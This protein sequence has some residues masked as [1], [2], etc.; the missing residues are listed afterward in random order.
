MTLQKPESFAGTQKE[1]SRYIKYVM[2]RARKT[3][4]LAS[5]LPG[6]RFGELLDE[7]G[8][9]MPVLKKMADLPLS[10]IDAILKA[11]IIED[12]Y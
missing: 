11:K 1:F 12:V 3:Y 8:D 4:L 9:R 7:F 5:G 10:E 2:K 6:E